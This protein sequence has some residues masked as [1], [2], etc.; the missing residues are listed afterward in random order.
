MPD[1]CKLYA[2]MSG[3]LHTALEFSA[4]QSGSSLPQGFSRSLCALS[5]RPLVL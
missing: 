5:Y 2:H 1:D 4:L 3:H